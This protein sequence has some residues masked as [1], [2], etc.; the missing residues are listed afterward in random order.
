MPTRRAATASMIPR[1]A[2]IPVLAAATVMSL[3][4]ASIWA[5]TMR[6]SSAT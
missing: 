4:T 3:V 5:T 2:S 6:G 1:L